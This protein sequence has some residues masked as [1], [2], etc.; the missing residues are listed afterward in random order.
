MKIKPRPTGAHLH[1]IRRTCL[2]IFYPET[3]FFLLAG[4]T[5]VFFKENPMVC[6]AGQVMV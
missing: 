5:A 1:L 2:D 3:V 4:F 6:T